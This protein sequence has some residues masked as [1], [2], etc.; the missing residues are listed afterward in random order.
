MQRQ[1]LKYYKSETIGYA[2]YE[3]LFATQHFTDAH[4]F[5]QNLLPVFFILP[6]QQIQVMKIELSMK[7][8]QN[9]LTE[10]L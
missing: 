9:V 2:D 1:L 10:L 6:C 4:A 8:N 5:F 7:L 3:R